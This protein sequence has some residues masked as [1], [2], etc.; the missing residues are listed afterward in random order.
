MF[1]FAPFIQQCLKSCN[2]ITLQHL[3]TNQ[4]LFLSVVGILS[5]FTFE[6]F[7]GQHG[8]H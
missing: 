8:I 5:V 7:S 6:M 1:Q 3:S 4:I 2:Y